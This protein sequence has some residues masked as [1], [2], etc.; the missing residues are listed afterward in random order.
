M[1]YVQKW[2]W[3]VI[4][5]VGFLALLGTNCFGT[6][7]QADMVYVAN[8]DDNT[9]SV[10]DSDVNR[11]VATVRVEY[12]PVQVALNPAGTRIYVTHY[13]VSGKVSV[14]D[15]SNNNVI[16]T[17]PVESFSA[18]IAVNPSGTMVYIMGS[19]S[20]SVIDTGSNS[21]V[22]TI[23]VGSELRGIVINP[24]GTRI[25]IV[26]RSNKV[27]V[28]DTSSNDVISTIPIVGYYSP[29]AIAIS[30]T[31]TQVY[32]VTYTTD[33]LNGNVNVIDTS[34]NN[35]VSTIPI[36]GRYSA[37]IAINPS[38]T[39]AYVAN[40]A[41]KNISVIDTSNNNIVETIPIGDYN[42]LNMSFNSTGTRVY[43]TAPDKHSVS[44]IDTSSNN[45]IATIPVGRN[46]VGIAV[47]GSN[48]DQN[49]L[50]GNSIKITGEFASTNTKFSGGVSTDKINYQ[51]YLTT[52][53]SSNLTAKGRITV[54]PADI[55]KQADLLWV[56]G[57][58]NNAPFDGGVDTTY[59][60][61][62]EMGSPSTVDLY[63]QPTVWMNQLAE[64]PFK[65][66]VT[67]QKETVIDEINLGYPSVYPS[68]NYYFIGYRL[69][70]GTLVYSQT[71]II[72]KI[73]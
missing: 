49:L 68:V 40:Y 67:L 57:I 31:G 9:I 16:S 44:V 36:T 11:V 62:D 38:G 29:G 72:S 43:L 2:I 42:P 47:V 7:A 13:I 41:N 66:N 56:A 19:S 27:S 53:P 35:V 5:L 3:Q 12:N 65:R 32:V 26:D 23:P 1:K 70:D 21:V 20:I 71:P 34:N 17:I 24:A 37:S 14:I 4:Q 33:R 8:R 52:T 64:K 48:S 28:I 39:M 46:P 18:G 73:E 22:S 61:M 30:P 69:S 58:E 59:F 60:V 6:F 50:N 15:T 51:S 55:G 10:I 63:N 45:V 25:Y 54:D